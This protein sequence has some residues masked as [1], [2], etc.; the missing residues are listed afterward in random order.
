MA[1]QTSAVPCDKDD[2]PIWVP[3][4]ELELGIR[5]QGT[6]AIS[7]GVACTTNS[8]VGLKGRVLASTGYWPCTRFHAVWT[9][10]R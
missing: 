7:L 3:R 10:K 9:N 1:Q 6:R 8:H 5:F 4:D 2:Q